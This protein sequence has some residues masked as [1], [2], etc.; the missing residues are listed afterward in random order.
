MFINSLA[1]HAAEVGLFI[2]VSK[3]KCMTT[4]K[5]KPTLNL[6]ID[7]KLIEQVDTFIY[8]GHKL[9]STNN[10]P[11]AVQHRIELGWA[12]FSKHKLLL[13]SSRVPYHIKKKIYNTYILPVVL[14]GL[15]CVNWTKTLCTKIEVFQNHI[16]RFMT[17]HKLTDHIKIE[18][19][20]EIT[21]LI[22]IM[23]VIKRRALKLFGHIKRSNVG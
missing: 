15:D 13:T 10:G 12:S 5:T 2:N 18:T 14:Y 23:A 19:L 21:K 6:T 16:M 4:D 17:N 7:N 11:V 8:L 1:K 3:T 22:P 20:R 9:S